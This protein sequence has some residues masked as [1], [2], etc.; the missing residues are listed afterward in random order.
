ML[1]PGAADNILGN[2]SKC[3]KRLSSKIIFT[4][5]RRDLK[6]GYFSKYIT[7]HLDGNK[8]LYK[9]GMENIQILQ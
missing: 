6:I 1:L 9:K 7:L 4:N 5:W 3:S 8:H 2:L